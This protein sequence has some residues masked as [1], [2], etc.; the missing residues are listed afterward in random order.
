MKQMLKNLMTGIDG[1]T[2]DL[3]RVSWAGSHVAVTAGAVWNAFHGGVIDLM[4]LA[5]AHGAVA[6]A[7]GAA[8][9]LKEKTE[10]GADP[11]SA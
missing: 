1:V 8:L 6:G 10:P 3:G 7:H 2:H 5:M 4:Q 9:K 11:P